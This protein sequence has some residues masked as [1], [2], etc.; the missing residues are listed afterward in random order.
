MAEFISQFGGIGLAFLGAAL[1][2]GLC[3]VGSARGT[4]ITGEAA[5]GVLSE[6]PEH[7][8]KCLI[9]QVIPGTQGLYGLVIWFFAL[10]TMGA[11]SGGILPLTITQGLTIFVSCL[12]M[13]MG[14]WR[15]A[16]Y[17]GRVAAASINIV[18]KKPDD[19]SKGIILCVIVEFYA[20]LSLLASI[21]LLMNAL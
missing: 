4:G 11:F 13:A 20:I 1:A 21:L 3:C 17:Q 19:W 14:G 12:P 18:A 10:Y 15:S 8:S 2:V 7:F 6:N 5:T 16:I 9:L